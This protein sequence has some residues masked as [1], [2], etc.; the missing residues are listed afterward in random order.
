MLDWKEI[1]IG[2][3]LVG[4]GCAI[5]QASKIRSIAKTLNTTVDSMADMTAVT[6][7]TRW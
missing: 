4:T 1:L 5:H 6:I 2:V 7:R 3:G